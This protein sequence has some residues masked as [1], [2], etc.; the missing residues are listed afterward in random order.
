MNSVSKKTTPDPRVIFILVILT[1]GTAVFIRTDL[2]L[3]AVL[4]FVTLFSAFSLGVNFRKTFGRLKRLLQILVLVTILRSLFSPSGDI[5][6]SIGNFTILTAG[7]LSI[8]AIVGLRLFVFI[9][10]ASMFTVYSSR[11]LIQGLVQLKMPY[12]LAFM[13]LIGIRFVPGFRVELQNSL[14]V[15]QLRGVVIEELKIKKRLSLYM[16]LLLPTLVSALQKA[17]EL[18]MSLDMRAFRAKKERTS[19][20]TLKFT[21]G[22]IFLFV[23]IFILFAL[24]LYHNIKMLL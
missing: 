14:M 5:L 13:I 17:K 22:D 24:F 12:E 20:H 15:L 8:G 4:F 6:F 1:S 9:L 7:G 3:M 18:T 2:V 11:T 19:F 10:G 23:L 21:K 16:Y